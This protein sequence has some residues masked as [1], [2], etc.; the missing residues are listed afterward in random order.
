MDYDNLAISLHL[1]FVTK[2]YLFY[3]D[4]IRIR[5]HKLAHQLN[6]PYVLL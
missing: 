6:Y 3:C 5:H 4:R 1:I 2:L